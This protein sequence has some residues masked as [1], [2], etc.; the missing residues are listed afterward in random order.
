MEIARAEIGTAEVAGGQH[1]P[2]IIEYHASTT[3]RAQSDE[4]AWCASF[5]NWVMREAGF[6]GTNSAA[7][8][9]WI[10]WGTECSL[11]EGAI[12]VIRNAQAA[13]SSLTTSGN[14]VG[15][16]V[17]ETEAHYVLLGGNQGNQVKESR[18]RKASW[19]LRAS[20]W[21]ASS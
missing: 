20:R 4:I 14:H 9:S 1:N 18:F 8:A 10:K 13:G 16:L 19:T 17:E 2:R 21:P 6:Q 5:V 15:F 12:V 7:A 11:R 3:L